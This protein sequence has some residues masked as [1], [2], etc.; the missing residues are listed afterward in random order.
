MSKIFNIV[1]QDYHGHVTIFPVP[2]I[3]DYFRVITN[4]TK[5]SIAQ[6][7]IHSSRRTYPSKSAFINNI[8]L[9]YLYHKHNI[10]L[11][12]FV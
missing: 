2:K 5:E 6:C 12:F 11:I 9:I 7:T 10:F 3:W 1:T 8:I 4:P